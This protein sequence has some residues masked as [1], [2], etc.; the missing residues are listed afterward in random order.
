MGSKEKIYSR[1][2][3]AR[4]LVEFREGI[5]EASQVALATAIDIP[6][7]TIQTYEQ[8]RADIS[9]EVV[10]RL[11]ERLGLDPLWLLMGL[12]RDPFDK[13]GKLEPLVEEATKAVE[14]V[15]QKRDLTLTPEKHATLVRMV[16]S[17]LRDELGDLERVDVIGM[18]DLAS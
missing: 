13:H 6:A 16:Y 14:V 18:V 4:R 1:Q 8:S 5:L 12:G 10:V 3:V 15:L 7:R 9:V 17:R 2:Q 11:Y